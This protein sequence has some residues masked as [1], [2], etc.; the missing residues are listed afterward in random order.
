MELI[1]TKSGVMTV[2]TEMK[3]FLIYTKQELE[4]S[5]LAHNIQVM[6]GYPT[7]REYKDMVNIKLLLN[8]SITTHDIT[9]TNS[10][11]GT[12][13]VYARRKTVRN[14]QRRVNVEEYVN[15]PEDFT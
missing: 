13:L 8:F 15:I 1:K 10:M 4:K 14:K 11:F 7:D 5:K 2:H 3:H 9:N 6:V 12:N